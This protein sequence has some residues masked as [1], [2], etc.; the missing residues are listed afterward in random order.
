V[1]QRGTEMAKR[2][3][4]RVHRLAVGQLWQIRHWLGHPMRDSRDVN[5]VA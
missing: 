3:T 5:M 4:Q 1:A 2:A